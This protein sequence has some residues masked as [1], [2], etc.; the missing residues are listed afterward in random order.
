MCLW[1][2]KKT[3]CL[4][5][6]LVVLYSRDTSGITNENSLANTKYE[7]IFAGQLEAKGR[8]SL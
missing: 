8:Y 7:T 3:D 2:K 5:L 4:I 6:P 1:C